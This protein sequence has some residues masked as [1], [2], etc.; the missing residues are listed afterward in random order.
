MSG[1]R[2]ESTQ[3]GILHNWRWLSLG[4]V[5]L[6]VPCLEGYLQPCRYSPSTIIL[7]SAARRDV[8]ASSRTFHQ[9]TNVQPVS[10]IESAVEPAIAP[11]TT[12]LTST[13]LSSSATPARKKSREKI[14]PMPVTGYYAEEILE[15]YDRRPF[16]VIW[17]LNALGLP[18]LGM[19]W[20]IFLV[21]ANH[22]DLLSG[23]LIIP[24]LSIPD[25]PIISLLCIAPPIKVGT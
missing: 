3:N 12:E 5:L 10:R 2:S 23:L 9:V 13:P 14:T 16:Q 21:A 1:K 17:R 4:I 18:L 15:Y 20:C 22:T 24:L 6:P 11:R 8:T 7:T 25:P 19:F